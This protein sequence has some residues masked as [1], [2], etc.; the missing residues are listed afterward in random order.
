M[1]IAAQSN[2]RPE[3]RKRR[4][5]R[6]NKLRNRILNQNWRTRLLK[7]TRRNALPNNLKPILNNIK[8]VTENNILR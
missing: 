1:R 3:K 8:N 6:A 2:T 7:K 4:T 5:N